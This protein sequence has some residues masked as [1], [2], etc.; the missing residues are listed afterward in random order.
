MGA[1]CVSVSHR[2]KEIRSK[3]ASFKMA[4][5]VNISGKCQQMTVSLKFWSCARVYKTDLKTPWF[6]IFRADNL[7]GKNGSYRVW[8]ISVTEQICQ[9]RNYLALRIYAY[10]IA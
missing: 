3:W 6:L 2:N 10:L 4:V 7:R 1:L 8:D 9:S 5:L